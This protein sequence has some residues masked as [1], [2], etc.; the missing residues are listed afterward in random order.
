[1]LT[2]ILKLLLPIA[3]VL[4]LLWGNGLSADLQRHQDP[5]RGFASSPSTRDEALGGDEGPGRLPGDEISRSTPA[6]AE[7]SLTPTPVASPDPILVGAGD[8]ASCGGSGDEA[9]ADLL[10]AIFAGGVPGRVFTAG[11]N[12]YDSGTASEFADCYGPS[13]GRHKA[14]TGPAPGNHDYNTGGA[15]GYF[16]YFGAAAGDPSK[17]YYSYDL[18]SWHIVVINSNCSEVGGCGAGSPQ[19]QWLRAD[20]ATHPAVCTLAYW[21]HP[22][23]SSGIHGSSTSVQAIWQALYDYGADV[24]V[25][26]HDH[27]YER[28]APQDP[29]GVADPERGIRQF[30]VGTGG[31]SHYSFTGPPAANGEVRNGGAFGVLKLTLHSTS[32]YW[33]FV[34]V[35]GNTFNDSGSQSCR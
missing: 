30:V 12:A 24:V 18:G 11:D 15:A 32:L 13:W 25:N 10:D 29:S 1:M 5:G 27:D 21:H 4:S 2:A 23:F 3:V 9:T 7:P 33:E 35:A 34:P 26:G 22:R 8:I 20:L 14:R 6:A 17:G 16:G 31:M 28:F 19:E